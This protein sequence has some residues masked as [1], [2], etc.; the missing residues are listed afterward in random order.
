YTFPNL[1]IPTLKV[2]KSCIEFLAAF[3]PVPYNC[4]PKSCCCYIGPHAN[5]T[6]CTAGVKEFRAL[7]MLQDMSALFELIF[8]LWED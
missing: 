4:C 7:D 5:E 6:Q 2:T 1:H 3:K 8:P